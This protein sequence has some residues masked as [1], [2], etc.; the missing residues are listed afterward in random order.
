MPLKS[1]KRLRHFSRTDAWRGP[2]GRGEERVF[3]V[4]PFTVNR[5]KRGD[6]LFLSGFK[7]QQIPRANSALQNDMA[8][9]FPQPV[10]TAVFL[11]LMQ[12]LKPTGCPSNLLRMKSPRHG[13]TIRR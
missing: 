11:L 8:G 4:I 6:L 3:F 7:K 2:P 9:V 1:W 12:N 5:A 10:R 13:G